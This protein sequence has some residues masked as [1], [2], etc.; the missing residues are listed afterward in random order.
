MNIIYN[1]RFKSTEEK[2]QQALFTLLKYH[3][4]NDL[5][6]KEICYEAGINRSTFYAHYQDINDLMMKT[7]ESLSGGIRDI[8][9]PNET[10]G[11]SVFVKMFEYILKYKTF[12]KAYLS[13]NELNF[14]ER[15]DFIDF[16]KL[17]KKNNL[18]LK[19]NQG[20]QI[21]HMAF[22]AG[23]IKALTKS[24]ILNDC[25][26]SPEKMANILKN[27]YFLNFAYFMS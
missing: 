7:E 2:I 3:G 1:Q 23:G 10:W 11:H 27:E 12:Y 8:F 13:T 19:F 14:M 21:Y 25:K 18:N 15:N 16:I 9:R 17:V 24:W 6:I 5:S 26:E 20:E 4:Y 22:F